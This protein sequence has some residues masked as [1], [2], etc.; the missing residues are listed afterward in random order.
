MTA[1]FWAGIPLALAIVALA[2]GVP[3]WLTHRQLRPYDHSEGRA[4]L[5]AR[6]EAPRGRPP[7]GARAA[8]GAAVLRDRTD[9]HRPVGLTTHAPGHIADSREGQ[10]ES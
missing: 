10:A 3:Y 7:R 8:R 6:D 9:W 4:Y 2:V 1:W 5:R